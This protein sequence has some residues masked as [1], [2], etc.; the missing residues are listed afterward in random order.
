M[1]FVDL[2]TR[3]VVDELATGS[4]PMAVAITK[5]GKRAFV[6]QFGESYFAV[7]DIAARTFEKMDTGAAFNEEFAIDDTGTTGLLTYGSAGNAV[8]FSVDDPAGTRGATAGIAG[9][10]A[11]AAFFPGTKIAYVLEAPTPL[12]GSVGGHVLID[13]TE[14]TAPIVRNV[15]AMSG[16]PIWYPIAAVPARSSVAFPAAQNGML[17]VIEMV[18]DGDAARQEQSIDVGPCSLLAHGASLDNTGRLMVAA[19]DELYVAIVD[20]ATGTAQRVAWNVYEI[21]STDI[22]SIPYQQ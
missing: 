16:V 15:V 21:G 8:T 4:G 11:G 9:D 12:T 3:S 22:K 17:S 2:E 18:L 5:D 14:P 10:A 7:V 6:G 1:L 19:Q 13:A 20:L